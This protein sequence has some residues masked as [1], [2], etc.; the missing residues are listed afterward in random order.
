MNNAEKSDFQRPIISLKQI[1]LTK[2]IEEGRKLRLYKV[3]FDT[4]KAKIGWLFT[5]Q[6]T[7]EIPLKK[8]LFYAISKQNGPK[9][10]FSGTFKDPIWSDYR[11]FFALKVSKEAFS[12]RLQDSSNMWTLKKIVF[13]RKCGYFNVMKYF[14]FILMMR[15]VPKIF[16]CPLSGSSG[17]F[18]HHWWV[19]LIGL[20]KIDRGV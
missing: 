17:E 10:D 8:L 4:F 14:G 9:I 5:P 15:T 19:W 20:Q 7:I 3:S 1:N 2:I 18:G 13:L 16:G 6:L 11:P 12:A